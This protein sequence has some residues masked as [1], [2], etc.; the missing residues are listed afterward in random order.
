MAK[1]DSRYN[2]RPGKRHTLI[3]YTRLYGTLLV[4]GLIMAVLSAVMWVLAPG[5]PMLGYA[6][7]WLAQLNLPGLRILGDLMLIVVLASLGL[8]F[9]GFYGRTFS[10]VQC[11]FSYLLLSTPLLR[12]RIPYSKIVTYAPA[13][14][15]EL[16]PLAQQGWSQRSYLQGVMSQL[17]AED[18][19]AVLQMQIKR[20]PVNPRLVKLLLNSYMISPK[21]NGLLIMLPDWRGFSNELNRQIED[22]RA[23]VAEKRNKRGGSLY[24]QLQK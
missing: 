10:F 11:H 13:R 5:L 24:S 8:A 18:E 12:M 17:R 14:F 7:L 2:R 20:W 4:T 16:Y 15:G 9:I 22:Y 6:P 1:K 3:L 19:G 23:Y 21:V